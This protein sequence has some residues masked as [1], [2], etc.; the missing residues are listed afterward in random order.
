MV[1]PDHASVHSRV[2]AREGP[3]AVQHAGLILE[4][5]PTVRL[6]V[7]LVTTVAAG[8]RSCRLRSKCSDM[9]LRA[10]TKRWVGRDLQR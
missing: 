6:P 7:A 2:R 10:T 4:G 3:R 5:S 1:A 8:S 9:W